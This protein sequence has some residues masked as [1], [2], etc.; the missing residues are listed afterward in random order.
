MN[1]KVLPFPASLETPISPPI[2]CASRFGDGQTQTGAA[3]LAGGGSVGLLK[4]LEEAT[5]LLF[6]EA[7]AGVTD[8]EVNQLAVFDLPLGRGLSRQSRHAR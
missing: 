5:H 6:G 4:G 7:D 2:N 8:R 1:Q 3:V